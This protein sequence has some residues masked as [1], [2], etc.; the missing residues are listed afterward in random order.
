MAVV[1]FQDTSREDLGDKCHY[2]PDRVPVAVLTDLKGTIRAS[3]RTVDENGAPIWALISCKSVATK[4]WSSSN[5]HIILAVSVP[6]IGQPPPPLPSFFRLEQEVCIWYGYQENFDPVTEA[7]LGVKLLRKYVGVLEIITGTVTE[8]GGYTVSLQCRDRVKWLMDTMVTFNPTQE[9]DRLR[10]NLQGIKQQGGG[11]LRSDLILQTARR[12]IGQSDI[13]PIA[14]QQGETGSPRCG[15]GRDILVSEKYLYDVGTIVGT[16]TDPKPA[17]AWY[18]EADGTSPPPLASSTRTLNKEVAVNPEFRIF[19]TRLPINLNEKG[20]FLINQQ[21][22][23]EIIKFLAMQETY[24]TEVFQDLR[25][26]HF[27]Y[28]PRMNDDSGFDDAKRF[29]RTY[30]VRHFP[31]KSYRSGDGPPVTPPD[32]NQMLIRFK[33]EKSSIGM[34]T[35]ILIR[36]SNVY[37]TGTLGDYNLHLKTRPY[38]LKRRDPED[39]ELPGFACKFMVYQDETIVSA[40]ESAAIAMNVARLLARETRAATAVMIG[41]PSIIPGEVLQVN[42][43]PLTQVEDWKAQIALD[44]QVYKT[45]INNSLENAKEYVKLVEESRESG[46]QQR[47]NQ[48]KDMDIYDGTKGTFQI[49]DKEQQSPD[50]LLCQ[51]DTK[52]YSPNNEGPNTGLNGLVGYNQEP[53]TI[54]RVEAVIDSYNQGNRE[55]RTE[56]ALSS[57]F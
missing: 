34:K 13:V 18:V 29:Y 49:Q 19:T 45:F 5:A 46:G 20:D 15:C 48:V 10:P 2:R 56:L 6:D 3:N 24:P 25:D 11:Q 26:G 12:G 41:D 57:P 23:I 9:G 27:Y 31:D 17:N 16:N 42:G 21:I 38:E 4:F 52:I 22:P 44:R 54:W 53:Q 7:D 50:K 30:F 1:L 8:N 32:H 14:A 28:V 33:E 43:S 40:Q 55:Y 47:G 35:N 51:N 36:S 37:S 39:N